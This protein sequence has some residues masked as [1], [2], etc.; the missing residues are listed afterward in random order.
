[1]ANFRLKYVHADRDRH[2]NVRYYYFKRGMP[3]KIRLPGRPGTEEFMAA[4]RAV[5]AGRPIPEKT[6]S[7]GIAPRAAR[8]SLEWL[9]NAFYQSAEFRGRAKGTQEGQKRVYRLICAEPVSPG[10]SVRL[11]EL[12]FPQLTTK[13]LRTIRDRKAETP[14]AANNWIKALRSLYKWA[15]EAELADE[16]PARDVPLLKVTS[17]GFHTWTL[18]EMRQYERVHPIG[19]QARLAMALLAYTGQRKSDVIRLGPQHMKDGRFRFTQ[20]KNETR[21]PVAIEIPILPE[22]AE[23]IAAT[24]CDHLTFLVNERGAPWSDGG[25]G[26]KFHDW[27]VEAGLPHCSSHG[28]RKAASCAAAEGGATEL[29]MM[30]IFGWR[31]PAMARRYTMK[32]SQRK[33]ADAAMH[34][35]GDRPH[36]ERTNVSHFEGAFKGGGKNR[37]K[38]R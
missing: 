11:G 6:P 17:D 8:D 16:N 26:N 7:N 10:S 1:M 38:N 31:T 3:R 2:G 30:A 27:C 35:L 28:L 24:P 21:N 20:K 14:N 37:A 12:P 32:A 36:E 25:F 18:E 5:D 9:C 22:L 33:M 23:I 15:I 13:A 4:Y 29:Q 34:F 19:G